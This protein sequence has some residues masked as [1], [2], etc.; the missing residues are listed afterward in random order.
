[1]H[2]RGTHCG[3]SDGKTQISRAQFRWNNGTADREAEKLSGEETIA[4]AAAGKV[5]AITL[6]RTAGKSIGA[7][8]ETGVAARGDETGADSSIQQQA[9]LP[10]QQPHCGGATGAEVVWADAST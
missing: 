1:M 10:E 4:G 7:L 3:R 6:A 5:H 2:R 9:F 8:A